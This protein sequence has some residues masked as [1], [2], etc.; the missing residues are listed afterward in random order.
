M[1]APAL[2]SVTHMVRKE[3]AR[4]LAAIVAKR[5]F[6]PTQM[7]KRNSVFFGGQLGAVVQPPVCSG[8]AQYA[9]PSRVNDLVQ[10]VEL[11]S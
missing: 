11:A 1:A 3:V 2:A 9:R 10:S 6:H 4:I 5:P 8:R 7:G